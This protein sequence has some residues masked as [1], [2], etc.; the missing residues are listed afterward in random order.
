MNKQQHLG[1]I[2]AFL[3]A[4]G[5]IRAAVTGRAARRRQVANLVNAGNEWLARFDAQEGAA[6]TDFAASRPAQYATFIDALPDVTIATA[7]PDD[8]VP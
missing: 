8:A 7:N 6:A 2:R 3:T 4:L 5:T 1:L